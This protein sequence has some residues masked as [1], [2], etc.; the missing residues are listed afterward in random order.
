MQH[1]L[2]RKVEEL[3]L[4]YREELKGTALLLHLCKLS[5]LV[6]RLKSQVSGKCERRARAGRAPAPPS[7][8]LLGRRGGGAAPD[9]FIAIGASA[10]S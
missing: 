6:W 2:R 1:Y 8:P 5:R 9:C 10:V 4:F 3:S 7:F